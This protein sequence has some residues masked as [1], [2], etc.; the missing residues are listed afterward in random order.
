[1]KPWHHMT[2]LPKVTKCSWQLNW[3][4][5]T[6]LLHVC[7][8]WT[9]YR[10]V[11]HMWDM[12]HLA[13]L[14]FELFCMHRAGTPTWAPP[15]PHCSVEEHSLFKMTTLFY[16]HCT[17]YLTPTFCSIICW[18]HGLSLPL[19]CWGWYCLENAGWALWKQLFPVCEGGCLGKDAG[20][21]IA[22]DFNLKTYVCYL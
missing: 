4:S 11:L 16:E 15:H 22:F 7:L 2:T 19:T 12:F 9:V 21:Q 3:K 10:N 14:C 13:L 8:F 20:R 17:F 5:S 18:G 6:H 1:M